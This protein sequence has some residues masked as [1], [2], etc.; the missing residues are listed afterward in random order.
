MKE[1]VSIVI[2]LPRINLRK[3]VNLFIASLFLAVQLPLTPMLTSRVA[4]AQDDVCPSTG[5]WTKVEPLSGLTY[6]YTP[7]T[8]YTVTSNC[9]KAGNADPVYGTGTTVTST[10][11]NSPGGATCTAPGVPHNGCAYQSLSH[12]SFLLTATTTTVTPAEATFNDVCGTALDTYTIPSAQTG[13]SYQVNTVTKDPG[14]YAG[15]GPTTI[16]AVAAQN[17][18]LSGT[19]TWSH[20]FTN[21]AC[22]AT[23]VDAD[24][25][26]YLHTF[27]GPNGTATVTLVGNLPLCEGE[28]QDFAL[29]SY[30]TQSDTFSTSFPQT[31][32]DSDTDTITESTNSITLNVDVPDC[33]T[34]VDLVWDSETISTI[35]SDGPFYGSRILGHE[36]APGNRSAGVFGAYNG[37]TESCDEE[38]EPDV[39]PAYL[40][41]ATGNSMFVK[42][43]D[44]DAAGAYNGHYGNSHQDGDDIIPPFTYNGTEY[45]QNWDEAGQAIYRNDCETPDEEPE[46]PATP[47]VVAVIVPCTP[48]SGDND[49]VT[50]SVTNTDDETNASVT[51]TVMLGGQTQTITLADGA[52]GTLTF[53]GLGIGTYTASVNGD[54]DTTAVSNSVLVTNCA[55]EGEIL[56]EIVTGGRGA[57][58]VQQ[59]A[60]TGTDALGSIFAALAIIGLT[61][62]MAVPTLKAKYE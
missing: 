43:D 42:I 24:D 54:D 46:E 29:V 45:S 47:V 41:H 37:G 17:Y 40:C 4:A 35:N 19:T 3:S 36:N 56:G 49:D 58:P 22:P 9:Y 61:C 53:F 20:T 25:A 52:T 44:I 34:Q 11:F 10:I 16:T 38:E 1:G 62:A 15:S 13:V 59:L 26:S 28:E 48:D 33:F 39:D 21:I 2:K 5:G 51:Y 50:V 7:P 14:T 8:G 31:L 57:G 30:E 12:A 55:E 18:T 60:N 23:C 27:D 6:T 32:F